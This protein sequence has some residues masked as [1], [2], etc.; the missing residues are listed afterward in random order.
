MI[1][2][3]LPHLFLHLLVIFEA[4]E[5]D[6][7]IINIVFYVCCSRRENEHDLSIRPEMKLL[8]VPFHISFPL[9]L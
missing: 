6:P 4:G 9:L 2:D 8:T 7:D 3:Q 5:E 1:L